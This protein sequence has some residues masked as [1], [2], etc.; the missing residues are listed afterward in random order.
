M[1]R[2]LQHLPVHQ[3]AWVVTRLCDV[4]AA[5]A[6]MMATDFTSDFDITQVGIKCLAKYARMV[7][8]ETTALHRRKEMMSHRN[9]GAYRKRVACLMSDLA[10]F[11][12]RYNRHEPSK[13]VVI[14]ISNSI[15]QG[16]EAMLRGYIMLQDLLL[17]HLH[18][19]LS[20]YP[21]PFSKQV[22]WYN[23]KHS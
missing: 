7:M 10:Q 17:H 16:V 23:C 18:L 9:A 12:T 20:L 19:V 2:Q 15:P 8:Y 3:L 5:P 13:I 22:E 11:H 6:P 14:Y 21:L 4:P 1:L